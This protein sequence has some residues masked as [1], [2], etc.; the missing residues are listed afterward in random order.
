MFMTESHHPRFLRLAPRSE[1]ALIARHW[2]GVRAHAWI[3]QISGQVLARLREGRNREVHT[4]I[5]F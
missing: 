5:L 1:A 2:P 3:L 4:V